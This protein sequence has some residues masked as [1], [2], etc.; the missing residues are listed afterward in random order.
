M[1]DEELI[2]YLGIPSDHP[3]GLT[4]VRALSPEKRACYERMASIEMELQL[5]QDGLGPKPNILVDF[6]RKAFR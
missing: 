4:V 1:T 5:W 3:M 6:P 2:K